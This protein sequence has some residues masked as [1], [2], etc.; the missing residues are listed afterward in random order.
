[1]NAPNTDPFHTGDGMQMRVKH[2]KQVSNEGIKKASVHD[3]DPDRTRV[4]RK[5]AFASHAKKNYFQLLM[6][7]LPLRLFSIAWLIF[8]FFFITYLSAEIQA[9]ATVGKLR[10]RIHSLK[11]VT[12]VSYPKNTVEFCSMAPSRK[13]TNYDFRGYRFD[14]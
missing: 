3:I 5:S 8:C 2:L 6:E 11:D 9:R 7:D 14:P 12:K 13:G 4:K 1:M 10:R